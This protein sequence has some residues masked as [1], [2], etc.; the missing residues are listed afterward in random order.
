MSRGVASVSGSALTTIQ[1]AT[2]GL[3]AIGANARSRRDWVR[4]HRRAAQL[5]RVARVTDAALVAG[6][7]TAGRLLS[8]E[9]LQVGRRRRCSDGAAQIASRFARVAGA[10]C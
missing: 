5:T 7:T 10:A 4:R 1:A 9:A 8:V 2:D 6:K 3:L